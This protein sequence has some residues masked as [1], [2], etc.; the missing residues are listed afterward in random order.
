M[1]AD[2]GSPDPG[3]IL[4]AGGGIAGLTAALAFSR[5]GF[6]VAVYERAAAFEEVGAGLQLSPNAT[7]ILRRLGVLDSLL[8]LAVQPEAVTLRAASS[9]AEIAR[10]PLG[11]A[12]EQ[13]WGAPYLAVHRGDLHKIL[14]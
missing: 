11:Q 4:V 12:A 5:R 10:I 13:R 3:R 7:R 14:L 2:A 9:L 1:S 6:D 8:P